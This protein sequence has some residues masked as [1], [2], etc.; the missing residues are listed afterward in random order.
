M[1][2]VRQSPDE[3][4]LTTGFRELG[5]I[6][7][8][9]SFVILIGVACLVFSLRELVWEESMGMLRPDDWTGMAAAAAFGGLFLISGFL[10]LHEFPAQ[11]CVFD[12][13]SGTATITR[14]PLIR[15]HPPSVRRL[16]F[17]AIAAVLLGERWPSDC[18]ASIVLASGEKIGLTPG[19][20]GKETASE[21]A[22]ILTE[23]LERPLFIGVGRERIIK[24]PASMSG[25]AQAVPLNCPQCDGRLPAV[26][27][28]ADRVACPYCGTNMTV[29]WKGG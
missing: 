16:E 19:F 12:K 10:F 5:A 18:A 3:L 24:F 25:S 20:K 29:V 15:I 4:T 9:A 28:E 27:R 22:E 1:R 23:F 6:Y 11:N 2:I 21:S 13:R 14:R 7:G 8:F 17:K 26:S